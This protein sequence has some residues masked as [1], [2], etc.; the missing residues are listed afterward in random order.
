MED[1]LEPTPNSKQ[2]TR[3]DFMR[4][5]A[6]ASAGLAAGCAT[7]PVTG[8]SQLMLVSEDQEI[9]VDRQNAP[10]QFSADYGTVQ[11]PALNAYIDSVGKRLADQTHRPD[12][13]YSFRAVNAVS[14]NAY[15]FPGGSI[16]CTRGMLL[17]LENE[18]ELAGLL[19]HEL[20][21]VNARHT[22]QQ[23][24]KGMLL[25][26]T[27]GGLAA[28]AGTQSQLLGGLAQGLASISAGA[29]LAKYSRDNERQADALGMEYMVKSGYNPEG[30]IG[31]MD[32]LR[33]M[34]QRKP[35]A[36]ELMFAT[37]PMSEERYQSAVQAVR[38]Q[39]RSFEKFPVLRTRYMDHT[40]NLRKH[41]DAV[42]EMQK[43]EREM[44]QGRLPT[45]Q[46]HFRNALKRDPEDYAGLLMMAKCL[47]MQK[48]FPE[49]TPYATLAKQVY[50]DEAQAYFVSGMLSLQLRN[51]SAGYQ[52]FA[53]YERLLPGNP[54]ITF[55]M[56]YSQ[57]G[58][59]NTQ[60]A[61]SQYH[62]YLQSVTSGNQ[63]QY[64]YQRLVQ[65]GYIRPTR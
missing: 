52:D 11:D 26:S 47:Y 65:W 35:G 60:G 42:D 55:L 49:A 57:E 24:S 13:P 44:A 62:R 27:L 33:S 10:H 48:K 56:G 2:M 38:T 14:M 9:Q 32:I 15:A 39:Y 23:M 28:V 63:A 30:M 40:A 25:S 53:S 50:P 20:G 8:Q 45:A 46:E 12:M 43:G 64:A 37:H 1:V 36:M 16:A 3:R 34:S 7:N 29:L 18:A 5:A 21:H 58:M 19:G 59:G 31:L 6:L 4:I 22:A 17:A 41:K 54:N 51:F 61:A